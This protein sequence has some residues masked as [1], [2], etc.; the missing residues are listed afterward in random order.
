MKK[1]L[2]LVTV[3]LFLFA[4]L[5]ESDVEDEVSSSFSTYVWKTEDFISNIDSNI[6]FLTQNKVSEI[7]LYLDTELN[8]NSYE[9]LIEELNQKK[10]VVNALVGDPS[11]VQNEDNY[12]EKFEYLEKFQQTSMHPFNSVHLDVEYYIIS[13][14]GTK[15]FEK[16]TSKFVDILNKFN[17][18]DDT[19]IQVVIPFWYDDVTYGDSNLF[20][21]L[22]DTVDDLYIMAYRDTYQ[23]SN[24]IKDI[25]D[26]ELKQ[27]N[28]I[29]IVLETR[30]SSEGDHLYVKDLESL[31]SLLIEMRRDIDVKGYSIHYLKSWKE[32]K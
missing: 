29:H 3:A 4:C 6:Q 1:L 24:G 20:D 31:D 8:F 16:Y 17:S 19:S 5:R 13:S 9:E 15:K 28:Q 11:W 22:I 7:H 26:Y 18:I 14:K 21:Y 10:I 2:L 23:G 30:P 32:L 27:T 25:L 12:M